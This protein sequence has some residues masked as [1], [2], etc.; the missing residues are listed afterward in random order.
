MSRIPARSASLLTEGITSGLWLGLRASGYNRGQTEA[1][2]IRARLFTK[3]GTE[4]V[5]LSQQDRL[6]TASLATSHSCLRKY[7]LPRENNIFSYLTFMTLIYT[8]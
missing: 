4:P 3:L 1:D 6:S 7:L 2:C 5:P 8:A